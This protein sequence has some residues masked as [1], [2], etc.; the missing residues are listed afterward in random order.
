[1]ASA[2]GVACPRIELPCRVAE[3][4]P[5]FFRLIRLFR[6]QNGARGGSLD[7]GPGATARQSGSR[8][9]RCR[10]AG[11]QPA[12]SLIVLER[13]AAGAGEA[14]QRVSY[15]YEINERNEL[16]GCRGEAAVRKTTRRHSQ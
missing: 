13:Q 3:R 15:P 5:Y 1:M 7:I 4:G 11:V 16:R 10:V 14:S 2:P 12:S 9:A 6:K 8:E